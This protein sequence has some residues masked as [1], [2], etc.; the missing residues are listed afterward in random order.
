MNARAKGL[1]EIRKY[2]SAV[3]GLLIVA[4]LVAMSVYAPLA[5]PYE[6]A[7]ALW[8]GGEA[9]SADNPRNAAPAWLNLFPGINLPTTMVLDSRRIAGSKT[10]EAADGIKEVRIELPVE[11][12]F[13]GFPKEL[14]LV[15][16]GTIH[17][18]DAF[19]SVF[20]ETP[21]GRSIRLADQGVRS[22]TTIRITQLARV[23]RQVENMPLEIGLFARPGT[24]AAPEPLK[25]TYRLVV[26][27][28]LF[29]E[30]DELD[31]RLVVYGQ[32][33]GWA[34]TDHRRRDLSVALLWGAPVALSFGLLA[35]VGLT[36]STMALAAAGAWWGG[37]VDAMIQRITEVNMILP[38]LPVLIMVGTLSSRSIWVILG[39]IILFGMF[40]GGIKT[41]RAMFLQVKESSYIDAAKAYGASS[42]RIILRYMIPRVAPVAVPNF[43]VLIPSYVFL[44]ATLSVLGLGDPVLPTWGK[45]LEDAYSNG[46]LFN[47]HYYWVLG[48]AVLL[49]LTGLGFSL[50]G[51]ALDRI[52]NPRLREM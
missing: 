7:V 35:A 44:E 39:V 11:Y 41:F 52:F 49:V 18:A 38:L 46:A 26:D 42:P 34:G 14:S 15:F 37:W 12:G 10:W 31:A 17:G 2:P 50:L 13:D 43:V 23:Q 22:A 29:D 33:H 40:G 45:V 16:E 6:R 32:L 4:V 51:F 25:G 30:A 28:L 48:P 1:A 27:A 21:D 5:I 8:R 36:L 3:A 9:A 19:V 24:A 20:W 47:G